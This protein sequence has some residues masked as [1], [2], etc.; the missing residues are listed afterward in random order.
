M[1]I[2]PKII[3]N[4]LWE[5]YIYFSWIKMQKIEIFEDEISRVLVGNFG[6][7]CSFL[8]F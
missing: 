7:I 5:D 2:D 3:T 4:S 8:L 1:Q 6:N